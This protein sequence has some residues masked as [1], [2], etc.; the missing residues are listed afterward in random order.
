MEMRKGEFA[1]EIGVSAGR[2]SQYIKA[3]IIGPDAMVGQGRSARIIVKLARQ[4][5]MARRDPGQALGNGLLTRLEQGEKEETGGAGN[6]ARPPADDPGRLIQMER[7][8]RER[9]NNR[10]AAVEEAKSQGHLVEADALVR[11][12]GRVSQTLVNTFMGM[13]PDIAN[14]IS[15][16]FGVPQRDVVHTVRRVMSERRA[17]IARAQNSE[18]EKLPESKET[19]I[20]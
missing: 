10:I 12:V 17:N 16:Q 2:V 3:G 7:L 5:I 11:E 9:R 13:A 8:E 19:V 1:A 14:A 4:Q 15:A 20:A 6:E 18:A